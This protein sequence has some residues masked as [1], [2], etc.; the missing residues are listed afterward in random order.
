MSSGRPSTKPYPPFRS[1]VVQVVLMGAALAAVFLAGT[2]RQGST[3]IFLTVAGAAM[4]FLAPN[5]IVPWKYWWLCGGILGA[6]LLCL[7]PQAWFYSPEW[8]LELQTYPELPPL[9]AISLAPRESIYWAVLLAGALGSGL[10]LLGHPVRTGVKR[11]LALLGTLACATYAGVAI[12]VK[13]TGWEYPFFDKG[14]WAPPDFGFFPNRNHTAALLVTG[15]ILALGIIQD[16]WMHRRP[17]AFLL[18]G[19]SLG[20]CVYALF[21][22]SSSRGGVVFLV[23]GVVVWV[24]ALGRSHRSVPLVVSALV[25]GAALVGIFLFSE[26]MARTRVLG[27]LG[28]GEAKMAPAEAAAAVPAVSERPTRLVGELRVRIFRDTARIVRDYPLTGTGLGTYAYVFPFYMR[29]SIDE[30]MPVHPESDWL[31]LASEVG[32]PALLLVVVLLVVLIRDLLPLKKSKTWPLRWGIVA[33]ALVAVLHGLVDVPLHRV[34]LGWWVLVLAGLAFG[35]PTPTETERN[36]GWLVQ[37]LIFGAAGA[38]FLATGVLLIRA[39]WYGET[40]FPPYRA[41]V[42][43]DQMRQLVALGKWGEATNLARSEIPLSPMERG[44]YRELGYRE[45]RSGGDPEVADAVFLAERALNPVSARIPLDQGNLWLSSNPLRA[46]KLWG[47]ALIKHRRIEQGGGYADAEGFYRSLLLRARPYPDLFRSLGE[48]AHLSPRLWLVWVRYAPKGQ[49]EEAAKD[50]EL[51]KK[52]T[53]EQRQ[54]FLMAWW[55]AGNK[56]AL[57]TFLAGNPDW[58]PEAWPVRVRQL[59]LRK[60]FAAAIKA[61]QERYA[62]DLTLPALD[63]ASLQKPE[64]PADLAGQVA[65]FAQRGNTVSARRVVLESAQARQP[66]GFRLQCVLAIKKGDLAG[67]WQAMEGYLRETKRGNLP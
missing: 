36:A 1:T 4:I 13:L 14:G 22:Y 39:Q 56:E 45:I 60:D 52:L 61:V 54:G 26:G 44:I 38:V 21:F 53:S 34:E 49:I 16:A 17:L 25:I 7:L 58:E 32:I 40:P 19:G 20:A 67:A 15:S 66:E 27:M 51:L 10:F 43:V 31:M 28:W 2:V 37:R 3:G 24:A 63:A 41:K 57:E 8:R 9:T 29:E 62:I 30:A 11:P 46:G 18:A 42:A 5:R 64:M 33:A 50:A 23:V 35:N 55:N 48:Y 6:S 65:Y 59:V 47:E 12:F